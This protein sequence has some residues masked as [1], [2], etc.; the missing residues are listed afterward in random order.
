MEAKKQNF[1]AYFLLSAFFLLFSASNVFGAIVQIEEF[2]DFQDPFSG[3]FYNETLPLI[4]DEYGTRVE[5]VFR[6]FPLSFHQYAQNAAE[7]S[8]CAR[9]QGKFR[10]YHNIMFENQNNLDIDSLKGY[11][12]QLNLNR[13]TFDK[14]L[15]LDEKQDK[16]SSDFLDG[17]TKGVSGT[18]TFFINGEKVVGAQPY[19]GF[20][21]II[22]DILKLPPEAKDQQNEPIIG[23]SSGEVEITTYFGFQSP[24]EGRFYRNTMPVI[25]NE[26]ENEVKFVFRNFP[27]SF[28]ENGQ[29]SAIAGECAYAQG[30]FKDYADVLFDNQ[31]NLDESD[32]KRYSSLIGLNESKFNECLES[33]FYLPEVLDDKNNGVTANVTGTPTFFIKGPKGS[34]KIVGAQSLSIFSE[35][36]DKV[37]GREVK[38]PTPEDQLR[39]PVLGSSNAEIE[40]IEYCE[41]EGPFCERFFSDTFPTIKKKYIDSGKVKFVFRD[42][43][44]SFHPNSQKAAEAAQ[45]ALEQDE[46]WKMHDLLFENQSNLSVSLYKQLARQIGLNTSEFNDCIDS[47]KYAP[48]VL[49]DFVDGQNEGVSGT[50]TFFINGEKIVGAQPTD[51]FERKIDELL[52]EEIDDE[53]EE[54]EELEEDPIEEEKSFCGNGLCEAGESS[55]N[56]PIDCKPITP[57]T[58]E[59]G[60]ERFYQCVDGT[61]VTWC[62]C[63]GDEWRCID[64]PETSCPSKETC[65]GCS[66]NGSCIDVGTRVVSGGT[67]SYCNLNKDLKVQLEDGQSCQ[68]NYECSSNSCSNGQC[69]NLQKDIQETKGLLQQI[70]E[71]L[72]SFFGFQP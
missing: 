50:P 68:N 15:D 44:L 19:S 16:V 62:N 8:E 46:F 18:P 5:L 56:C 36:I 69:I 31:D 14:C 55:L 67:P 51:V 17:S 48:E 28:H 38:P 12:S 20:K 4:E 7:A 59:E 57:K 30:R 29:I 9:D 37:L 23:N 6:H 72:M 2:G 35:A 47:A 32:L 71:W 22:D 41:F 43:P 25:L 27:L 66:V 24:F 61:K 64:S 65:N 54:D 3:K 60:N 53:T 49:D 63:I 21:E 13:T 33:E 1:V 40:M 26:Y 42:F 52:G 39:E 11:A 58:C 10:E 70:M 45:C 34:E